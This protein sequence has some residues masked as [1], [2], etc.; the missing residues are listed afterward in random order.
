VIPDLLAKAVANGGWSEDQTI[1]GR[2][3]TWIVLRH[4]ELLAEIFR[5]RW[6]HTTARVFRRTALTAVLRTQHDI[7]DYL[8]SAA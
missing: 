7:A 5:D 4:G 8:E 2:R 1:A 3:G 6:R